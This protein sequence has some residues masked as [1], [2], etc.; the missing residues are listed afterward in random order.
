M[1]ANIIVTQV[2]NHFTSLWAGEKAYIF[3]FLKSVT[4]HDVH[5]FKS[6]HFVHVSC[7]MTLFGCADA[8]LEIKGLTLENTLHGYE[9][10]TN[11]HPV[12]FCSDAFASINNTLLA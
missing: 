6:E 11:A 7:K 3:W 12:S 10:F 4:W 9:T 8:C 2:A 5:S 1:D